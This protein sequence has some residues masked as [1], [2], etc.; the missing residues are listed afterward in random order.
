MNAVARR[1]AEA[2]E[3]LIAAP[4]GIGLHPD[5]QPGVP[6]HDP[7]T[8]GRSV[9]GGIAVWIDDVHGCSPGGLI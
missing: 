9:V 4:L 8:D 6:E 3:E 7:V 1:L 2:N 5:H